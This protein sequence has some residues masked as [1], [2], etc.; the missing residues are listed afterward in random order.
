MLFLQRLEELI[1]RIYFYEQLTKHALGVIGCSM[2]S[3]RISSRVIG[4]LCIFKF[5]FLL[6]IEQKLVGDFI[7]LDSLRLCNNVKKSS[8]FPTLSAYV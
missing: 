1:V 3:L 5:N 4:S 8:M 7:L 6:R 2:A